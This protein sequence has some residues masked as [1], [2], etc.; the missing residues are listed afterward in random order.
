MMATHQQL[1]RNIGANP[2]V[3]RPHNVPLPRYFLVRPA[4]T[5]HTASGTITMPG[6]MV[7]L[8]ALDQLPEWIDIAGVPRELTVEQTMGLQNLGTVIPE[9]T[10]HFEVR[11]HQ[12]VRFVTSSSSPSSAPK[13]RSGSSG[14]TRDKSHISNNPNPAP[15]PLIGPVLDPHDMDRPGSSSSSSSSKHGH[16]SMNSLS[17]S[18][19]GEPIVSSSSR[20]KKTTAKKGSEKAAAVSKA[21]TTSKG[22]RGSITSK[23]SVVTLNPRLPT[24]PPATIPLNPYPILRHHHRDALAPPPGPDHPATRLLS[25]ITPAS[26]YIYS[27]AHPQQ[28]SPANNNNNKPPQAS[29]RHNRTIVYCRHWC[30]HGSCKY[31]LECRYEHRMPQTHEGLREVGLADWPNWYRA[32]WTMA[33]NMQT[34][35]RSGRHESW[36]DFMAAMVD[37]GS[38]SR[39]K[40]GS[41][42]QKA[43]GS[44]S[45]SSRNVVLGINDGPP[46]VPTTTTTTVA[47]ADGDKSVIVEERHGRLRRAEIG[48]SDGSSSETE[49]GDHKMEVHDAAASKKQDKVAENIT[50]PVES[51]VDI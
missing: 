6:P 16:N 8:I 40:A 46:T 4:T 10:E 28:Q 39:R 49:Y 42:Q 19:S 1:H 7:P 22:P 24:P 29:S 21:E 48:D 27:P 25:A 23:P 26:G 36:P 50:P 35:R 37:A 38:G 15:S 33:L 43:R 17:D 9:A 44:G 2:R 14:E 20:S 31:G 12:D 45:G 11:L 51:L 3:L 5:K 34:S 13:R 30:H 18:S 32:A 47:H 41:S